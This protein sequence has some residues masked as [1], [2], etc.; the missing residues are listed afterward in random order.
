MTEEK[1]YKKRRFFNRRLNEY[2]DSYYKN[3]VPTGVDGKPVES[4]ALSKEDKEYMLQ[5]EDEYYNNSHKEG[6]IHTAHPEYEEKFRKQTNAMT[7]N[8]NEDFISL[9]RY[10]RKIINDL[11]RVTDPKHRN[12][13]LEDN[14]S[15][16]GFEGMVK[17][18]ISNAI[19]ELEIPKKFCQYSDK[20][21]S[22]LIL[23]VVK[24]VKM[25]QAM[26][27]AEKRKD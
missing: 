26:Q 3:R 4:L 10:D 6:T 18:L 23:D 15:V 21:I 17:T 5:F 16:I 19:D 27:R 2:R 14:Y 11:A 9:N 24:V 12:K 20:R 13:Q 25:E 8:R 7:N 22:Q 1:K